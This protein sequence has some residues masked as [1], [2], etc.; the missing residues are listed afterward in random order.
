MFK[1]EDTTF[2]N[3]LENEMFRLVKKNYTKDFL[4]KNRMEILFQ[5]RYISNSN[6]YAAYKYKEI[7]DSL[8]KEY[9]RLMYYFKVMKS[10]LEEIQVVDENGNKHPNY[11][12][13]NAYNLLC[14]KD[15]D[16]HFFKLIDEV[17]NIEENID[18]AKVIYNQF[19]LTETSHSKVNRK[20]DFN[21]KNQENTK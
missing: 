6:E 17:Q 4:D 10:V 13:Y 8:E 9:N 2:D 11:N 16:V 18:I 20:N 21:A 5:D 12:A 19:N 15:K 1:L 7:K 14:E 3:D